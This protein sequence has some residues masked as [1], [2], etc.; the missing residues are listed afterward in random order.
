M[1]NNVLFIVYVQNQI[2]DLVDIVIQSFSLENYCFKVVYG[3]HG[4]KNIKKKNLFIFQ[5]SDFFP[6]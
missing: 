1:I 4:I 2:A 5:N 6:S 3:S